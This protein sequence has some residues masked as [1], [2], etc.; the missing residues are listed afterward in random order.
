MMMKHGLLLF[1]P[2][3]TASVKDPAKF[4]NPRDLNESKVNLSFG[5]L[6]F[7]LIFHVI[8]CAYFAQPHTKPQVDSVHSNHPQYKAPVQFIPQLYKPRN[9]ANNQS[10]DSIFFG[11]FEFT[12]L[13]PL[14][15]LRLTALVKR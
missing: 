6:Q 4:N 5:G 10:Q 14:N 1:P 8:L 11:S 13:T 12:I 15:N 7:L 2:I 9:G 3:E